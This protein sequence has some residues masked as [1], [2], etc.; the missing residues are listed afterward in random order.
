MLEK[1]NQDNRLSTPVLLIAFNRSDT[2]KN[3]F[4]RI[5]Q[6]K[7]SQFYLAVDGARLDKPGETEMCKQCQ[8]IVEL[9]DWDCEIHT[10]FR[11]RNLGC[12]MGP[13]SA[14]SWAFETT[15]KLIILEDDCLPSLSF[16]YYC[17]NLLNRYEQ[18]KRIGI[19]SGLS[20][21]PKS[22][23]F[24]EA[25]YLFSHYAHTW[26]WA[27]WKDRWEQFDIYMSDAP[28]FLAQ[29]G[30]ANVFASKAVATRANKRIQNVFKSI[31]E[32]VKHSW[33]TQWDY[34]RIKNGYIDIVPKV[35][36]IQNVGAVGGTHE[37]YGG[38]AVEM[39]ADDLKMPLVHPAFIMLN[40]EYDKY[41]YKNYIHV[42]YVKLFF[43]AILNP[44]KAKYLVSI[45]KKKIS[46]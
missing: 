29:G 1:C 33:D 43:Q 28:Q 25:D 42:P 21:H 3:V 20:I 44:E 38:D 30:A 8:E 19:I 23:F 37:S 12:G 35:N 24:G 32:E 40:S 11:D 14:I 34:A 7:P 39:S 27:T 9:V 13:S 5:R 10:L 22:S 15:D 6:V 26:G 36:L 2:A 18:D 45:L 4:E 46:K 17:E 41:H 31:N 16:F